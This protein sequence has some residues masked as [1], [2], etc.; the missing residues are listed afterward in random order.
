MKAATISEIKRALRDTDPD[1]IVEFC[2]RLAKFKKDNKELLTYLLFMADDESYYV[3]S[4][5]DVIEGQ[6]EEINA[7]H[8][9]YAKKGIRKGLR[10]TN[11]FIKYS[12]EKTTEIELLVFFCEQMKALPLNFNRSTTMQ[13]LFNRQLARIEKAV[14]ALHEDLQHDYQQQIAGMGL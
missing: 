5:K 7:S 14:N 1:Q 3:Q 6:F 13:N 9:Y 10:M 12:G 11:Q 4:A 8:L 2:L